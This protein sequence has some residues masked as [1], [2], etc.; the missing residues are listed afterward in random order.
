MFTPRKFGKRLSPA[1]VAA[2]SA[3]AEAVATVRDWMGERAPA[4]TV[5]RLAAQIARRA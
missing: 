2:K 5:N 4:D 1:T 3:K